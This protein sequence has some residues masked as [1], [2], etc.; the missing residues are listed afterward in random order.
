MSTSARVRAILGGVI[1]AYRSDPVYQH[2]PQALAELDWIGRRLDQPIRIA[3]AG[4]LKAGKSTLVNALVGE[5]IAPT[6]ATEATRLVT[7]FRHGMTPR[8]T[9]NHRD[10]RR[11]DVP[12][13]RG[14]GLTFDLARYSGA[15]ANDIVDLDVQWPAAEL[16]QTTI[17]DTPGTSSLSRDVSDR[18]LQLLV[19]RDGVPRVDAVVFLLRTLNAPDIALLK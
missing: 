18:T 8:V 19:P 9:A 12:I 14:D 15:P 16:E 2:R 11:T 1:S 3:L 4:T 17:I 6:D 10:G 7:W 13:T 5:E